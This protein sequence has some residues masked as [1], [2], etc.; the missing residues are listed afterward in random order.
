MKKVI[1]HIGRA[2]F[3]LSFIG[4]GINHFR[5]TEKIAQYVP[6]YLPA[7]QIWVYITGILL[8]LL[9]LLLLLNFKTKIISLGLAGLIAILTLLV[10]F[11]DP[12]HNKMA[13]AVYTAFIGAALF[14]FSKSE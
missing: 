12:I 5:K 14:I 10:Y 8:I 7:H 6:D 13:I 4:F 1:E 2:L 9:G 11:P 3:S